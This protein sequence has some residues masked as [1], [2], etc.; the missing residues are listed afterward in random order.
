M[1]EI[2]QKL[3]KFS[4]TEIF[5]YLI[6]GAF[7]TILSLIV[8][9]GSY[10]LFVSINLIN[11][12]IMN[13]DANWV[14]ANLLSFCLSTIFAYYINK[15]FVFNNTDYKTATIVKELAKFFAGRILGYILFDLSLMALL[16][17]VLNLNV[18]VSKLISC[19]FIIVFNYVVSKLFVFVNSDE[20]N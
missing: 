3:Y 14:M 15:I 16:I 7:T 11:F 19:I 9:F 18:T 17:Y 10:N 20:F 12:Q 8:F 2:K 5:L 13:R 6:C 1:N 4:H